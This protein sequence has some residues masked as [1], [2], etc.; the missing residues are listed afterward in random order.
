MILCF[1]DVFWHTGHLHFRA[2]LNCF[3]DNVDRRG[4]GIVQVKIGVLINSGMCQRNNYCFT[5]EVG[6]S[7]KMCARV[8]VRACVRV[9]GGGGR[10]YGIFCS[11]CCPTSQPVSAHWPTDTLIKMGFRK[12]MYT[13]NTYITDIIC[14]F[15]HVKMC[16]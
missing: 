12:K 5:T 2:N 14:N 3:D 13:K 11:P 15:I 16:K 7:C 9:Y 6:A 1:F 8:P 4:T 10:E